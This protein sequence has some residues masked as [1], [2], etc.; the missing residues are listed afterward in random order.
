MLYPGYYL[1]E[2]RA[3][4]IVQLL[5]AKND[6]DKE[7]M[8]E[9][10]LDVTSPVNK[11]VINELIKL[12]DVTHLSGKQL[13]LLDSLKNWNGEYTLNSTSPVIYHRTLY[14]MVKNTME[15]EMGPEMFKQFL[16]THLFKRQIAW[17]AQM[18]EG[19]WWDNINTPN[20][21]ET[22][23]DI[24]MI[25]FAQTW[26]SLVKDFGDDPSQWTWDKVH[27]LEHQHP[28]GQV[29]WLR[30]Y[31]NVGPFPIVGTREVINNL[32]FPYD[33]TGFYKVNSGPSTRR[34]IDFSDIENSISIL[35]TG[36]S[37]NPLSKHYKDQA[38]MYVNGEF[39]KM[40][41]NKQEIEE[42]AE[43]VLIFY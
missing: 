40:M 1:P 3:K 4:R 25:S 2:N 19:E 17:G 6:W 36:Q 15:D 30:K 38:E 41:M 23:E 10:I 32:A 29:E 26:E 27:T 39:R 35:P 8:S 7:A 18:K 5:D 37:G 31:F 34:I 33:E 9:M 16:S 14:Q 22:R 11:E 12:F 43:S 13:V 28:F 42:T 20:V 24:V 21:V